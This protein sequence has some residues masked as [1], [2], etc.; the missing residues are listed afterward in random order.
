MTVKNI[1]PPHSGRGF[2]QEIFQ[3]K[4]EC[5]VS[6]YSVKNDGVERRPHAWD[7][8]HPHMSHARVNPGSILLG[9]YVHVCHLF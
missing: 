7:N 6:S 3:E 4:D 5:S 1:T 8:E 9:L 2:D